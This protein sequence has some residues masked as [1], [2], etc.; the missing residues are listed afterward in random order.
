MQ[1]DLTIY[2]S[3]TT[4][5]EALSFLQIQKV[6]SK[7]IRMQDYF[8]NFEKLNMGNMNVAK[9]C[10]WGALKPNFISACTPSLRPVP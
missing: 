7:K 10:K 1:A 4:I 3:R 9:P 8:G 6:L 2:R 5:W